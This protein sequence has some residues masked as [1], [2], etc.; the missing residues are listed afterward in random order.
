[1]SNK[2]C[3]FLKKL[4]MKEEYRIVDGYDGVYQVSNLGEV[5]S[6]DRYVKQNGG[7]LELRKGK[8]LKQDINK[9]R[10]NYHSVCLSK[11]G[12]VKRV[13]VHKLVA[14]AFPEICG[15]WFEGCEIDHLDCNPHNNVATNLRVTDKKGN[16]NNPNTK[17][18]CSL[19]YTDERRNSYSIRM[20]LNNPNKKK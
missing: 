5:R 9:Y 6:T 16:M 17:I 10:N 15:E 20:K 12:N 7:V 1:M 14:K 2:I 3:T 19:A 11:D 18:N 4:V 13:T 8:P